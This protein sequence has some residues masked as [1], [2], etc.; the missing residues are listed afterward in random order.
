[1][2]RI[3]LNCKDMEKIIKEQE[4]GKLLALAADYQKDHQDYDL[5]IGIKYDRYFGGR[6]ISLTIRDSD[7]N[8]LAEKSCLIE[9]SMGASEIFSGIV[10]N[11]AEKNTEDEIHE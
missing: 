6:R 7:Y 5:E 11:V 1:M 4:V 2:L 9:D 10:E 8:K 3:T